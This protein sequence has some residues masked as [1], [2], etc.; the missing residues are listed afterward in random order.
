MSTK[1]IY[2]TPSAVTDVNECF[3]YH[4]ADI[5]GHGHVKGVWDIRENTHKYL[6]GV[7]FRG[8]R[9][10][11]IGTASGF[12]CFYMESRGAEVVAFDL[13]EDHSRDI[14]PFAGQDFGKLVLEGKEHVR[15]LH[16]AYWF[17]HRANKSNAKAV[18]GDVYTIPEEIGAVDISTFCCVLLHVRDPF[19][20]L[21]NALRLTKD[22]VVVTDVLR[23]RYFLQRIFNRLGGRSYLEFMP[24]FRSCC[25]DD[26]WW[27]LN[28]DIVKKFIGALGFGK[29]E[30]KYHTGKYG[31]DKIL[32][33]TV[34]GHRTKNV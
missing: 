33:F 16:N 17:C 20:A 8:K 19:L 34:V 3:F 13:S 24:E 1:N 27:N 22:T 11:E 12:L 4:T 32:L 29:T 10:L 14:V 26:T 23:R 5:P 31:N 2:A 21:Q 30:V 28:P 6:G 9:V 15:K 7:D 18:Y 25:P